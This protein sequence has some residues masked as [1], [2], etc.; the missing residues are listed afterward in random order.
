MEGSVPFVRFH[1]TSVSARSNPALQIAPHMWCQIVAWRLFLQIW[2]F[3]WN[4]GWNWKLIFPNFLN[5]QI[6]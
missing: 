3:V 2:R 6:L 4:A 1:R 5:I